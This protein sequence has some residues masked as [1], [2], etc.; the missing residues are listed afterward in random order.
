MIKKTGSK[1]YRSFSAK[2]LSVMILEKRTLLACWLKRK[3]HDF[4]D[5]NFKNKTTEFKIT[6]YV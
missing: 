1:M 3:I 5:L 6:V 4:Y 2:S